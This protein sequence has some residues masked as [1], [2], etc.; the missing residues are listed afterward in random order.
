MFLVF[1]V[2]RVWQQQNIVANAT[3]RLNR[4]RKE[5]LQHVAT[6]TRTRTERFVCLLFSLRC[7]FIFNLQTFRFCFRFVFIFV[8]RC[9]SMIKEA[10]RPEIG[11]QF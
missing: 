7:A 6:T 8:F 9:S 1:C 5:M 2:C 10:K 11:L 4:A 3:S